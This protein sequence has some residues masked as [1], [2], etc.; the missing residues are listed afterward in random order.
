MSL[1]ILERS[2]SA[3]PVIP[4]TLARRRS[5][6]HTTIIP[7]QSDV[8]DSDHETT[9]HT[10]TDAVAKRASRGMSLRTISGSAHPE[11]TKAASL[12][13]P[14]PTADPIGSIIA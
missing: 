12:V 2:D 11:E 7:P 14:T 13:K 9:F 6:K 3:H 4:E 8:S 5:K 1:S 10:T